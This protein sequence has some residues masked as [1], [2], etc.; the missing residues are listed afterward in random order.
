M[1]KQSAMEEKKAAAD[2]IISATKIAELLSQ[3]KKLE[4]KRIYDTA[5]AN[6]SYMSLTEL[7]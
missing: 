3:L 4:D 7:K 1:I 6:S 2:A 5:K